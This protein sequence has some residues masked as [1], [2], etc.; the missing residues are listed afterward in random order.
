MAESMLP[1]AW[2]Q[3]AAP[4]ALPLSTKLG[5][6]VAGVVRGRV[7]PVAR[8]LSCGEPKTVPAANLRQD[9]HASGTGAP[10]V[11]A[12]AVERSV[13]GFRLVP[14]RNPR[15]RNPFRCPTCKT[16]PAVRRDGSAF[17]VRS[18]VIAPR[19]AV[20]ALT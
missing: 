6:A 19:D 18:I 10:T 4:S 8:P 13:S 2:Q 17:G 14:A 20:A 3:W 5:T 7:D 11:P 1:S 16:K 9:P 12:R 15:A